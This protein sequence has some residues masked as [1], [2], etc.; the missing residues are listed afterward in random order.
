[1]D[2]IFLSLM[3]LMRA[4]KQDWYKSRMM[5]LLD[6]TLKYMLN[7]CVLVLFVSYVCVRTEP[8][9]RGLERYSEGPCP[10]LLCPPLYPG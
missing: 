4:A 3:M 7:P 6:S 9:I 10:P 2:G 1:M 5:H 8:L